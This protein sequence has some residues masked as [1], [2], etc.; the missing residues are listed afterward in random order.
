MLKAAGI[1]NFLFK[2]FSLIIDIRSIRK[3][4][5]FC[6]AEKEKIV[7]NTEQGVETLCSMAFCIIYNSYQ[8]FFY[9]Y[10]QRN[11]IGA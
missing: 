10:L 9:S 4:S 11:K 8:K 2:G 7:L 6:Y 5:S 1:Y 3:L